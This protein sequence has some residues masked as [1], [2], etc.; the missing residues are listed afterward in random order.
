MSQSPLEKHGAPVEVITG[1]PLSHP[2]HFG[3]N[4]NLFR[5]AHLKSGDWENWRTI[6]DQTDIEDVF[7]I[8]GRTSSDEDQTSAFFDFLGYLTPSSGPWDDFPD[9]D[10]WAEM[11]L[12]PRVLQVSEGFPSSVYLSVSTETENGEYGVNIADLT[13]YDD[14]TTVL[15]AVAASGQAQTVYDDQ[16]REGKLCLLLSLKDGRSALLEITEDFWLMLWLTRGL[17]V[18]FIFRPERTEVLIPRVTLAAGRGE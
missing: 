4:E 14:W 12:Y 13:D 7:N 2:L 16:I 17:Q 8:A 18:D 5:I 15:D 10:L 3:A 11:G 6:V 9:V 1:G